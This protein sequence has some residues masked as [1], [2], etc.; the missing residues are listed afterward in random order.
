MGKQL[1]QCVKDYVVFDLE[2]TGISVL[3]D[4]VIEISALKVTEQTITADFTSLVNPGCHI[5]YEASRVN[6]ITDDMVR[7]ARPFEKVL[8]DFLDF[9]GDAVLV[10]HNICSFDLKFIRRDAQSFFGKP[11]DNDYIDTLPLARLCLPGLSHY[12]LTDLA[13]HYGISSAGAHR[14]ANDCRINQQVYEYLAKETPSAASDSSG[15]RLCA[16]CQSPMVRRKGKY[17]MFWGCSAYPACRHTEP[18]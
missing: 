8:P 3:S 14:A 10:G 18:C 11:L 17:G 16:K 2:T 6:G 15:I 4:K 1:T 9:I 12:R 7:D 5:P 13:A